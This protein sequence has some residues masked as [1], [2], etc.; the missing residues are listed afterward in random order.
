MRRILLICLLGLILT[1]VGGF[2]WQSQAVLAAPAAGLGCSEGVGLGRANPQEPYPVPLTP[3]ETPDPYP[4]PTRAIPLIS[5]VVVAALLV[6]I[7]VVIGLL[8]F[9]RRSK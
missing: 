3:K 7:V 5:L 4:A 2:L 6:V 8:Y 1:A 9:L